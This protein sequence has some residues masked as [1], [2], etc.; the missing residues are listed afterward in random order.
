LTALGQ[1]QEGLAL[2]LQGLSICRATG[3]VAHTPSM[4]VGLAEAYARLGQT[5]EGLNCLAEA[6]QIIEATDERIEESDVYRVR[7]DVLNSADD[8][9]AAEKSYRQAARRSATAKR[10]A[11]RTAGSDGPRQAVV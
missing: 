11:V 4:L 9:A 7:G 6:R 8:R 10:K 5:G 2:I 1:A 3:A